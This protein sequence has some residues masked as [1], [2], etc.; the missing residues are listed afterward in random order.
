MCC[1]HHDMIFSRVRPNHMISIEYTV[2]SMYVAVISYESTFVFFLICVANTHIAH[3]YIRNHHSLKHMNL[4]YKMPFSNHF[5][6]SHCDSITDTH[7]KLNVFV[8]FASLELSYQ[9]S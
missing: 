7:T 8:I 1:A 5:I 6:T 2:V 9:I 3:A 4:K